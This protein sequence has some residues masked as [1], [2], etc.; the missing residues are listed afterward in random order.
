MWDAP[1]YEPMLAA[2]GP[3]LGK[4]E[5]Y[6]FEPKWDGWRA[7]VYVDDAVTVRTRSGRDVSAKVQELSPLAAAL[8]GR[9]AVLDGELIAS[10]GAPSSF[11]RIAGR[12]SAGERPKRHP[13][14]FVAF[15]VLYLDGDLTTSSYRDRREALEGLNLLG[16]AWCTTPSFP[17]MGAELFAAC[18][19]LG[20]EGLVAKRLNG[21]YLPGQRSALWV[22][23]K[24]ESWKRDHAQYR[25]PE[26]RR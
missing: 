19:Q 23:A 15:D 13:L 3:I 10:S 20:L 1:E 4:A 9:I 24:C 22:K 17:G 8:D 16:S 25:N 7:L 2:S 5:D 26:R 18:I 14:T 21:R 6:A 12:V 11:Y